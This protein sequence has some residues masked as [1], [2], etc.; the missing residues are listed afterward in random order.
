M[1]KKIKIHRQLTFA[2]AAHRDAEV[3]DWFSQAFKAVGPYFSKRV[4]GTGLSLAEQKLLMP[5]VLSMDPEDKDFK[6]SVKKFFDEILTI[7][8]PGGLVLEIGLKEDDKLPLSE[9]NMPINIE[10]YVKYRHAKNHPWMALSKEEADRNPTKR[11]YLEDPDANVVTATNLNDLEDKALAIYFKYKEDE[12]RVNQIL[13]VMGKKVK[14][15]DSAKKQLEFKALTRRR[16]E[17]SASDQELNLKRFIEVSEDP[18]LMFK[19]LVEELIFAKVLE[20]VGTTILIKETNKT[21]GNDLRSAVIYLKNPRNSKDYN[22]LRSQY[23]AHV[24]GAIEIPEL[25]TEIAEKTETKV[26]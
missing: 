9:T 22:F 1:S 13:T 8:P 16:A 4:T 18:D 5:H 14:T 2:Q 15:L 25:Q 21:I 11:F 3:V 24:A 12:L 26:G 10:D 20:R 7:L 17:L 6:A 23:Q 19:F